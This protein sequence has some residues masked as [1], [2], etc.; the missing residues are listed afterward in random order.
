MMGSGDD[1]TISSG[2]ILNVIGANDYST[3]VQQDASADINISSGGKIKIGDGSSSTGNGYEA[4]ATSTTNVWNDGAIYEYDINRAFVAPGLTY[5]P[6]AD[7]TTIPIFRVSAVSGT[8][9]SGSSS[10]FH[11]NGILEL[12]TDLIFKELETNIF[13]RR[14]KGNYTVNTDR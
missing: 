6:N 14:N 2:G 8:P 4:F 5:F 9:G 11:L 7:E 10:D 3:S 1:I 13:E 12:N